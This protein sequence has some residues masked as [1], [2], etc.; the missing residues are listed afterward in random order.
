MVV[1]HCSAP[2]ELLLFTVKMQKMLIASDCFN[3][4]TN[5]FENKLD[6]FSQLMECIKLYKQFADYS[7]A[8]CF[9][10]LSG[11][12]NAILLC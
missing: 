12:H 10:S 7:S 2:S 6:I 3:K 1:Q 5:Q 4:P 11:R 8:F 9:V